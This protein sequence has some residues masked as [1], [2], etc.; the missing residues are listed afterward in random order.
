MAQKAN[1]MRCLD[2]PECRNAILDKMVH[3]VW[4]AAGGGEQ[5]GFTGLSV[6]LVE[7][8][9]DGVVMETLH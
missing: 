9:M 2:H 6:M 4:T 3:E 8:N 5:P 1:G 7:G